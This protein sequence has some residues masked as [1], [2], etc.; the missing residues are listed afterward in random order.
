METGEGSGIGE[1]E[2]ELERKGNCMQASILICDTN[3]RFGA[4]LGERTCNYC[5]ILYF[6]S[7]S[8]DVYFIREAHK[9]L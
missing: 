4:F 7:H 1:N 6:I 3:R 2:R 5:I 9:S 8:I